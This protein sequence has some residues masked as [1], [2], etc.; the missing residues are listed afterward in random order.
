M[1][2]VSWAELLKRDPPRR[3]ATPVKSRAP[4][5]LVSETWGWT[6]RPLRPCPW[7]RSGFAQGATKLLCRKILWL[8]LWR[9]ER[10]P[11]KGGVNFGSERLLKPWTRTRAQRPRWT[12]GPRNSTFTTVPVMV[13]PLWR[14]LVL[15]SETTVIKVIKTPAMVDPLWRKSVPRNVTFAT[16]AIQTQE[17][18]FGTGP[19][20]GNLGKP[21]S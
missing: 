7:L 6:P 21:S 16:K 12:L 14:Q 15:R 3:L 19:F 10:R 9:A 20:P 4:H 1:V 8:A 18:A 13:G 11:W 2:E 5:L 17:R